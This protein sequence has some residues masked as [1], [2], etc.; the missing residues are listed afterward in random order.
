M[1]DTINVV[2]CNTCHRGIPHPD[3]KGIMDQKG[4]NGAPP[5]GFPPP[6]P[7]KN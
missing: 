3:A 5:P 6:P 2:T 4:G 7:P 1:P